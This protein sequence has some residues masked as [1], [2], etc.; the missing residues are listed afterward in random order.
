MAR[1]RI[2]TKDNGGLYFAQAHTDLK[3][4]PTGSR[5]L[6]LALGGGWA[7]PR[8]ANIVGDRSSG[9]SLLAI[10]AMANFSRLYP[11][12]EKNIGY[13]ESEHAFLPDYAQALGCP[14]E[15]LDNWD[16]RR[17]EL[18][19][20]LTTVEDLF[21]DLSDVVRRQKEL[22]KKRPP[23]FLHITDSLDALSDEEEMKHDLREG[24]YGTK[25]AKTMS[26]LFRRMV[27]PLEEANITML[28]ISQVRSKIG[29]SFG[30]TTTRAGGRALDFYASQSIFLADIGKEDR[31]VRG[32]KR[33]VGVNLLCKIDK[34][35]VSNSYRTVEFPVRFGFGID[36]VRS[37][38]NWL[39]ELRLLK[40]GFGFKEET[41]GAITKYLERFEA[42]P[43]AER[44]A[45]IKEL[46]D[47]VSQQWFEIEKSLMPRIRKYD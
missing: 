14:L 21:D 17:H 32:Q 4:I 6:D 31:T 45:E 18:S 16:A 9:K 8:I 46:H 12:R 40:K 47:L 19:H 15:R 37:C 24:S 20:P 26:Q 28:I 3:F 25:K 23:P 33:V 30:R 2:K 39:Y 13:R 11:G 42:M 5:L 38:L 43:P 29:V 34:N 41:K 10:E 27:S 35:K 7:Q 1:Q 22:D 36:D 44:K